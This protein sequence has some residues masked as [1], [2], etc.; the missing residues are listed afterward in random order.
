MIIN[1]KRPSQHISYSIIV[2]VSL[3]PLFVNHDKEV[4]VGKWLHA[5]MGGAD[6]KKP[7]HVK[8]KLGPLAMRPGWHSGDL[9]V[10]THIGGKTHAGLSK[11]NYRPD[12][13]VWAQVEHPA[14]H[15]W[16]SVANSRGK[17]VKAHITDQVPN[18]GHYRY[19]T[20]PNMT[21][22]WIISGQMKVN[23]ILPDHEVEAINKKAGT[24]DLPRLKKINE[25]RDYA[26][27]ASP[28]KLKAIAK[29]SP[30][31]EARFIVQHDGKIVAGD[32][33]LHTHWDLGSGDHHT[34]G[35]VFHHP[36]SN[37]HIAILDGEI[38]LALNTT[39]MIVLIMRSV[40]FLSMEV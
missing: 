26:Y 36:K 39:M 1:Q 9:P 24:A 31:H 28:S 11:P 12:H 19:K 2:V 16:Q 20:N 22:N 3:Y 35:F 10:A 30:H 15:D 8:S 13:Q 34:A 40:T 21:G 4:P 18:H 6:P 7:T 32:A 37:T 14:D 33:G 29:N 38:I 27:N 5:D 23:R 25:D 17:G